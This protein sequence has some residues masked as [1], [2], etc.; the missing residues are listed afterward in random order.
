MFQ[1]SKYI[2]HLFDQKFSQKYSF[3]NIFIIMRNYT[4]KSSRKSRHFL[5]H[6][7]FLIFSHKLVHCNFYM[8]YYHKQFHFYMIILYTRFGL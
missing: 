5:F 4:I 6:E 2:F 8:N 1:K 3:F 7:L